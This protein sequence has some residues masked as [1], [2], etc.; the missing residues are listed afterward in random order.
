MSRLSSPDAGVRILT[1]EVGANRIKFVRG[2]RDMPVKAA[3]WV[4]LLG[5]GWVGPGCAIT[6]HHNGGFMKKI[7]FAVL[8]LATLT[9]AA[10]M[11][12]KVE[13]SANAAQACETNENC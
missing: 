13:V 6:F 8:F 4:S 12:I 9:A 10:S 7:I 5:D 1:A 3:I 11:N 2:E